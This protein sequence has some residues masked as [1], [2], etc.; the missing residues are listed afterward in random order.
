M[1]MV[2][3]SVVKLRLCEGTCDFRHLDVVIPREPAAFHHDGDAF[4][5]RFDVAPLFTL[6]VDLRAA[7]K[8][9]RPRPYP[10][11]SHLQAPVHRTLEAFQGLERKAVDQRHLVRD[12]SPFKFA[13]DA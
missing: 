5:C 11:H 9:Q 7:Q 10:W 6:A 4:H 13:Y 12:A 2:N 3:T 1:N 8:H